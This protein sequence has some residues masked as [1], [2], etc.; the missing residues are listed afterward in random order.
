MQDHATSLLFTKPFGPSGVR[1]LPDHPMHDHGTDSWAGQ[2][3]NGSDL[4]SPDRVST[5][6]HAARSSRSTAK[7]SRFSRQTPNRE[8]PPSTS[9]RI[10]NHCQQS[11]QKAAEA[12]ARGPTFC[13]LARCGFRGG[14]KLVPSREQLLLWHRVEMDR[15]FFAFLLADQGRNIH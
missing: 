4:R 1:R 9:G 10:S 3:N 6:V 8:K 15:A 11:L 12:K 5:K 14:L 7:R 2:E 13:D